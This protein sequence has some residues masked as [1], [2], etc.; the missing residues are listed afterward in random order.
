MPKTIVSAPKL[1]PAKYG[2]L[3]AATVHTGAGHW[4]NGV[5]FTPL[6][7]KVIHAHDYQ[8]WIAGSSEKTLQGCPT[9]VALA[10]YT[11]ELTVE[12]AAADNFDVKVFLDSEM[13]AG[14]QA[15][16]E[17]V[18]ELGVSDVA[19]ATP[20]T[21]PALS[22]TIS[23]AAIKGR[24][25]SGS[26]VTLD[27]TSVDIGAIADAVTA[28]GTLE[29]KMLDASDHIG[30]AGVIYISPL[31]AA[32]LSHQLCEEN[33]VMHSKL[34][35]SKVVIGNYSPTIMYGHTG[36]VEVWIDDSKI[37][38]VHHKSNDEIVQIEMPVVISWNP[39][40][41]FNAT[42]SGA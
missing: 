15:I 2:L 12:W 14:A 18:Q 1:T 8:C 39:C 38:I 21:P 24:G 35:G 17:R 23:T 11:L 5:T 16:L 34:T 22:G 37:D 41:S 28:L 31:Q 7:C 9:A 42:V 27:D 3:S 19:D 36:D 4:E 26:G 29:A 25:V 32:Q 20:L 10:P 33:G 40:G 13:A 6:G 30:A